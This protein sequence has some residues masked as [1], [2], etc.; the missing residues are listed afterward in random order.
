MN[1]QNI[2]ILIMFALTWL[3]ISMICLAVIE[4]I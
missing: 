4:Q 3:G 1:K 2:M